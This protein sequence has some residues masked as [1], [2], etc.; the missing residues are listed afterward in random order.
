L[1]GSGIRTRDTKNSFSNN[2]RKKKK[3]EGRLKR[4]KKPSAK[5]KLKNCVNTE[6]SLLV[7]TKNKKRKQLHVVNLRQSSLKSSDVI[8]ARKCSKKKANLTIIC[9]QRS[10][11]KLRPR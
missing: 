1:N 11:R 5:L 8:F 10:T 7:N 3:K 9:N 4:K 6:K 2:N